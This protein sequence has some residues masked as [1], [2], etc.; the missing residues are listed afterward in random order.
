M[1]SIRVPSGADVVINPAPWKDAKNLKKAIQKELC[2]SDIDI[3]KGGFSGL[4]DAIF[5]V[6]SSDQV[7]VALW[8]CLIRCTYNGQKITETTFDD[9]AARADYYE[10][11]SVC[12][13]ENLGPLVDSLSSKLS[14]IGSMVGMQAKSQKSE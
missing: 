9:V 10:V 4:I 6:D 2:I 13:K 11:I 1:A 8:P 12:I 3:A 5:K 14:E 7:D